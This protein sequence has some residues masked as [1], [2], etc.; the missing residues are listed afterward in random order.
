PLLL[1]V[2]NLVVPSRR[3]AYGAC[4]RVLALDEQ[5]GYRLEA[6]VVAGALYPWAA[7]RDVAPLGSLRETNGEARL[8][9]SKDGED[10]TACV[11][12]AAVIVVEQDDASET[13]A[14]PEGR[15]VAVRGARP[16]LRQSTAQ[17]PD[18]PLRTWNLDFARPFARSGGAPG[19]TR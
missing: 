8:R 18:A 15:L 10:T 11:D 16:P 17:K 19:G 3:I 9:L 14:P 1:C 7:R 12:R 5:G 4:P 2:V 6:S 13:L